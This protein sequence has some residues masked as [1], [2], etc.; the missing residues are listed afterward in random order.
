M[1]NPL[2]VRRI[3]V[4]TVN[5]K[6]EPEGEPTFGFV[7]SDDHATVFNDCF[8]SIEDLNSKIEA[9]GS[10]VHMANEHDEFGDDDEINL[11]K[12]DNKNF[13]GFPWKERS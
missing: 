4:Q 1:S 2:S 9:A 12:V 13:Y 7:A 11:N 5:E 6:G 10:I 3:V 8:E